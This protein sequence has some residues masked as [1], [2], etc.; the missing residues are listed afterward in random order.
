MSSKRIRSTFYYLRRIILKTIIPEFIWPK[1]IV[2]DSVPI[3][4]RNT[5]YSFG[6]KCTLIK[7]DYEKNERLLINNRI[8]KGEVIFEFGGSI[9][10]L[11][12]ILAEKT[13]SNGMIISVEA[14]VGLSKYSKTWLE[15]KQNIKVVNGYGFPVN[16]L[17]KKISIDN[18]DESGGSLGGKVTFSP[19]NISDQ[20]GGKIF[21][22]ER[23]IDKFKLRPNILVIDIEGCEKIFV[24]QPPMFPDE[25]R[26]IM[27]ELH[28]HFYGQNC[29]NSII[30][31]IVSEGFSI[32]ATKEG[33]YL[34]ER[35]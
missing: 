5:P 11:T 27:I 31:S 23:L 32:S 6:V 28:P 8:K 25:V 12:S 17:A 2:V 26:M 35:G 14:S 21:D 10:V 18:F 4:V 3:R 30:K 15:K 34:F 7:G 19:N 22:L 13:G 24:D 29:M 20:E 1:E 9:G 33:V 16:K